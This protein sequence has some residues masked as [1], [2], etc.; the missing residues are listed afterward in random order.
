MGLAPDRHCGRKSSIR[1]D[2]LLAHGGCL[3]LDRWT[4]DPADPT[5]RLPLGSTRIQV[6]TRA[7][8]PARG[9][10]CQGG[11]KVEILTSSVD[12]KKFFSM[13]ARTHTFFKALS[14]L[15]LGLSV[16]GCVTAQPPYPNVV[17]IDT[18]GNY[19]AR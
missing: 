9:R 18:T 4:G 17:P 14:A 3:P 16:A 6:Q 15:A 19:G 12:R 10:A 7:P 8:L 2:A 5:A 11:L 13:G 1:L